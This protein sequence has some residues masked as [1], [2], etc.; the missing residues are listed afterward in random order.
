MLHDLFNLIGAPARFGARALLLVA[1]ML[2]GYATLRRWSK[3]RYARTRFG[4]NYVYRPWLLF[5]ISELKQIESLINDGSDDDLLK[6]RDSQLGIF[7]LVA[8]VVRPN[9]LAQDLED[10]AHT[11]IKTVGHTVGASRHLCIVSPSAR[12]DELL[13]SRSLYT[14]AR[15]KPPRSLLHLCST[16]GTTFCTTS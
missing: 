14:L 4:P 11:D 16:A 3:N 8:I 10:Y 15:H 12:T 9:L 7:Q 1:Y 2:I 5:D 13:R 6:L